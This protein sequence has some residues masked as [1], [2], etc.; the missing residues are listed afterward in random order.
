MR[1]TIAPT[2]NG[3][4]GVHG[5]LILR[6]IADQSF[7]VGEC[8]VAG[9]RPVSLIVRD[10]LDFAMLEDADAR[11]RRAEVNADRRC[12][13][14]VFFRS[15]SVSAYQGKREISTTRNSLDSFL[16]EKLLEGSRF[17]WRNRCLRSRSILVRVFLIALR[18]TRPRDSRAKNCA[19]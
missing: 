17:A 3:V 4:V 7:R 14:H 19:Y 2:E 11:V 6:R 15:E 5:D 18:T 9:R 12:A 10:D 13:C 1:G 8:D 16:T